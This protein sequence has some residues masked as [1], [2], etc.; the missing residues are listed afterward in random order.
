MPR[1]ASL[2]FPQLAIDRIRRSEGRRNYPSPAQREGEGLSGAL[3]T[4]PTD[5]HPA[6]LPQAGEGEKRPTATG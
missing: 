3:Q 2:Y 4:A 6:P 1:L 5:P